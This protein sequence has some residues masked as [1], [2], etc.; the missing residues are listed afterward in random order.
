MGRILVSQKN[1]IRCITGNKKWERV[2]DHYQPVSCRP[3]FKEHMILT[4]PACYIYEAI[5]FFEKNG[6]G[7][8]VGEASAYNTRNA[9]DLRL[10]KVRLEKS[11]QDVL[12][13]GALFFNKLPGQIKDLRGNK[14]FGARVKKWLVNEVIYSVAEYLQNPS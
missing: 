9:K 14:E 3:I 12:Y 1:A 6:G 4:A 11:K 10:P 5:R 7:I 8:T 13:A 2:G